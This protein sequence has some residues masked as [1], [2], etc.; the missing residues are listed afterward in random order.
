VSEGSVD[1]AKQLAEEALRLH[2]AGQIDIAVPLYKQ[3]LELNSQLTYAFS[4]LGVALQAQGNPH[5]AVACY[6]RALEFEPE[7]PIIFS[8]LGNALRQLGELDEAIFC[9]QRAVELNPDYAVPHF[10][11]GLALQS[12]GR[13]R[14]AMAAFERACDI[15]PDHEEA[16]LNR[17]LLLL[18]FGDYQRGWPAY[19]WRWKRRDNPPAS[20]HQPRWDGTPFPD[21]TL[22][23]HTEQGFGDVIQFLRFA[24]LVKALGGRV[25]FECKPELYRLLQSAPGIDQ[26][27]V[28]GDPF[29]YFDL[30]CP[31]L[32]VPGLI[33]TTV[34][35][36]PHDVPY[37]KA[38]AGLIEKF[39]PLLARAGNRLKVG[40]VWSGSVTFQGN[41]LRST[42]LYR[43]L[44]LLRVPNIHLFSLQMGP[45]REQ[46]KKFD[47][48]ALVTDVTPLIEDFAD[49]AALIQ[50]LDLVVMTDS[51]VSHLTG[52]LNCPV[53]NLLCYV[54]DWRWFENR[55]DSPW[56]PS[57]RLFR[58][59]SYN[60]WDDVFQRVVDALREHVGQKTNVSGASASA[61]SDT[62][63]IPVLKSAFHTESG[64]PRF[65]MPIPSH[66]LNDAGVSFLWKH[67]SSFGGYEYPSR[68]FFDEHLEPGDV[69][70]DVGAHWGIF[71]LSAATRHRDQISVLAI[72]AHPDN[73]E[74]L[75]N[76]VEHNQLEKAIEV[77]AA[78][79][80]D[81][82]G[83]ADIIRDSTMGHSIRRAAQSSEQTVP[84]VTIDGLLADR[85]QLQSRRTWM[86]ID[87]E[88]HEPEVVAGSRQLLESGRVAGL[89][90]EKGRNYLVQP[91]F[92]KMMSMIE[93]IEQLGFSMYR[94]PHENLGGPLIPFVVNNDLCN[95]F[96]LAPSIQRRCVYSKPFGPTPHIFRPHLPE[97]TAVHKADWA[98]RM[99]AV[100]GTDCG[101]WVDQDQLE[102]G[103]TLRAELASRKIA[104]SKSVLDLG[105]GKM[106][107]RS[108]LAD[109]NHYVPADLVQRS[110][111]CLVVDVNQGQFPTGHYD[112]I[113]MLEVL[114]Y[115]HDAPALLRRAGE[116][117]SILLLTYC[118]NRN[119]EEDDRRARGWFNDYTNDSL[120][121]LLESSG[122][123]VQETVVNRGVMLIVG[124]RTTQVTL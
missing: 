59:T 43:F 9:Q 76:W 119:D 85:A 87:V 32:S 116:A 109:T 71:S 93:Y 47:I 90:W 40:I 2:S 29:P 10:N 83:Q 105:A 36:I 94:F 65:E 106:E 52:A 124:S 23:L 33:G 56:Y 27:I 30:Q 95:V 15:K 68:K 18:Q 48:S 112:Y 114:E 92:E 51:S 73:V 60:D 123:I 88:G 12:A 102:S 63:T 62:T 91:G 96:A 50:Q 35:T 110:E 26:L 57:M 100:R 72:E 7:N 1:R 89:V 121:Q 82:A 107:L 20:F 16:Q 61:C 84:V 11:H 115:V 99:I 67:E 69:F 45:R 31:L 78:A 86:K 19:E 42:Q 14:E 98:R 120:K 103:A 101:R 38:P 66:Y 13:L 77:V 53:W 81:Q 8:N 79:A 104:P 75:C 55:E 25:V 4:S 111:D 70:L 113:V 80:G 49:T 41:A 122:W 21:K 34:D 44:E 46:L 22:L 118:V 117:G 37:L 24:P 58:Q 108:F 64:R 5:A 28:R 74:H 17:S 97:P 3:A 54:T 39:K 6:R